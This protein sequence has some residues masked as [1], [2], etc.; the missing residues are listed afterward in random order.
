MGDLRIAIG[1]DSDIPVAHVGLSGLNRHLLVVAP[2]ESAC[3]KHER[4]VV[5]RRLTERVV[6]SDPT[7]RQ[8]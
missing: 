1:A 8:N 2:T 5:P 3:T 4:E 7:A 6:I